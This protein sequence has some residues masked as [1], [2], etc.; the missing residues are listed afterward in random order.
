MALEL[1]RV[2]GRSGARVI[3][4]ESSGGLLCRSSRFVDEFYH[5]PPPRYRTSEYVDSLLTIIRKE[6]VDLLIPTCE[7]IF[8]ISKFKDEMP[9]GCQ[10]FVPEFEMIENLHRKDRF[11][12]LARSLNLAV[13]HTVLLCEKGEELSDFPD[14]SDRVVIKPV[15]SRFGSET[16]VIRRDD[17]EAVKTSVF[18]DNREWIVQEY[19]AGVE[20]H[21]YAVVSDGCVLAI[22]VYRSLISGRGTGPCLAFEAVVKPEIDEWVRHLVRELGFS[23][24]ISFDFIIGEAGVPQA[25]ECNPRATSGLH[26]LADMDELHKAFLSRKAVE[27]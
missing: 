20:Y 5:V 2:L 16:R 4:A 23:G 27:C 7:E 25:I 24:Q 18:H 19:L 12:A 9:A 13:P 11:V 1:S 10:V 21:A 17:F 14:R 6:G 3:V 22:V 8:F 15:Y 26:L